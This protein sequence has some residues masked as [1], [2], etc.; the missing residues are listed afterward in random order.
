MLQ[1]NLISMSQAVM[2]TDRSIAD[3]SGTDKELSVGPIRCSTRSTVGHNMAEWLER[4]I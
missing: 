3:D 4:R 1:Q 2:E